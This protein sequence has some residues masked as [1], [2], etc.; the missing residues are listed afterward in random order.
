[1]P[2][3]LSLKRIYD[4]AG[5]VQRTDIVFVYNIQMHDHSERPALLRSI[6]NKIRLYE[7]YPELY[8]GAPYFSAWRV[9][10]F[11]DGLYR[12]GQQ[13]R[14]ASWFLNL[15]PPPDVETRIH[16]YPPYHIP[17]PSTLLRGILMGALLDAIAFEIGHRAEGAEKMPA[18]F[19]QD[20]F[21]P[22]ES[23]LHCH[24]W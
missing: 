21:C 11:L 13:N 4:D 10:T 22:P 12:Y 14:Q 5:L 1:M 3:K 18:Y 6:A 8:S 17:F 7:I 23:G 15:P 24:L 16:R 9:Y 19:L 2:P 20:V